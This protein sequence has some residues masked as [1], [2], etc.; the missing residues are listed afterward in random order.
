MTLFQKKN[1]LFGRLEKK[2]YLPAD[3]GQRTI[4]QDI[5]KLLDLELLEI[6][7]EKRKESDLI[8]DLENVEHSKKVKRAQKLDLCLKHAALR[9]EYMY[10]LLQQVYSILQV[11]KSL[12]DKLLSGAL[13]PELLIFHLKSQLELE[14]IVMEKIDGID[15]KKFHGLFADLVKGEHIIQTMTAKEKKLLQKMQKR[16]QKVFSNE[17][18]KGLTYEWTITVF[19]KVQDILLDDSALEAMG[20]GPHATVDFEFVN[21]PEFVDLVRETIQKLKKR[22]NVS[23]QMINVFVHAFRE[24]YNYEREQVSAE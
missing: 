9:Y 14:L 16:L 6:H 2:R 20:S 1:A 10:A 5:K 13:N 3:I 18:K 8:S 17:L 4:L 7:D 24:W 19:N 15:T 11:Q 22:R 21:R 12:V 23:E